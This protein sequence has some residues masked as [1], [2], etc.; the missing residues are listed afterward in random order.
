MRVLSTATELRREFEELFKSSSNVQIA[1]AWATH[2]FAVECMTQTRGVSVQA[3]VGVSLAVTP[4]DLLSQLDHV[5]TLRVAEEPRNAIFHPKLYLFDRPDRRW[6]VIGSPNL[7]AAAFGANREVAISL[8]PDDIGWREL[9][10]VF[11]ILWEDATPFNRFDLN[12]Y[13]KRFAASRNEELCKRERSTRSSSVPSGVRAPAPV[14]VGALLTADWDEYLALLR[15]RASDRF[16]QG[17]AV[18]D[19][20]GNSYLWTIQTARPLIHRP[21]SSLHADDR[22]KLL[23]AR[24]ARP[25][26]PAF[27][28]GWLGGLTSSA[29]TS[30]PGLIDG[31]NREAVAAID[32]L[33]ATI[34]QSGSV[35]DALQSGRGFFERFTNLDGF[36]AAFATRFLAL[37]RPDVFCSVN[38]KSR[39]RLKDL[40]P[41]IGDLTT[42][43]GYVECLRKL[44]GTLW[45]KSLR[46]ERE[47]EVEM[48]EARVALVDVYAYDPDASE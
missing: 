1:A 12:A 5:C 6:V 28:Y 36:K 39:E 27:D 9:Q 23:G 19:Q 3:I 4:P 20:V 21:F 33:V 40:F 16:E 37:S 14:T 29:R 2:G 11:T 42:W 26:G 30:C 7:T 43:T 13:T 38:G 47:A 25:D 24:I 18:L 22:R 41:N 45:W 48:W 35:D 31:T 17:E 8:S 15:R 46:P 10:R 32:E 34:P 44:H